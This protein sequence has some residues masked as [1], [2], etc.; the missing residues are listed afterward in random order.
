[1]VHACVFVEP[2]CADIAR[3]RSRASR[4]L[5]H[6]DARLAQRDDLHAQAG[7]LAIGMLCVR[8]SSLKAEYTR[9]A[10]TSPRAIAAE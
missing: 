3:A 5:Q 1:V 9:C 6:A 2:L 7:V 8:S 10:S 4:P